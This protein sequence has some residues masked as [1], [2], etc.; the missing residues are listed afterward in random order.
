MLHL[1]Y[2]L[3]SV[4]HLQGLVTALKTAWGKQGRL[5]NVVFN[6]YPDDS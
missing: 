2:T 4:F 6:Y 1:V 3:L 5:E